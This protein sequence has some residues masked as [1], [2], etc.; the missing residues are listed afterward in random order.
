MDIDTLNWNPPNFDTIDY[1][2]DQVAT[3]L[4]VA[5]S[6]LRYWEKIFDVPVKRTSTNRRLYPRD[7]IAIFEKIMY[8]HADGY[9]TRG[10]KSRLRGASNGNAESKVI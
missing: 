10:I 5:K 4:G 6:K 2:I 7:V 1:N 3:I 8:L 9:A